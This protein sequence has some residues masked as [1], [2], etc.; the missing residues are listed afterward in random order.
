MSL[1]ENSN[2]PIE[3]EEDSKSIGLQAHLNDMDQNILISLARE[4]NEYLDSKKGGCCATICGLLIRLIKFVIPLLKIFSVSLF[5]VLQFYY[6]IRQKTDV[7]SVIDYTFIIS[8]LMSVACV[9]L[10]QAS[11]HVDAVELDRRYFSRVIILKYRRGLAI[12]LFQFLLYMILLFVAI[13]SF[14]SSV[15]ESFWA[16]IYSLN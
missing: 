5:V 15:F 14:K 8:A 7:Q 3:I 10:E 12:P 13:A 16:K 1:T 2:G 4:E 6:M 11:Q 9:L